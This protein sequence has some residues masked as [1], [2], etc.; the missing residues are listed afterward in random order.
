MPEQSNIIFHNEKQILESVARST[1][2]GFVAYNNEFQITYFS[3]KMEEV[4]GWSEKEMLGKDVRELYA[5]KTAVETPKI[6]EV[7][8]QIVI[9]FTKLG[10]QLSL[11]TKIT[12][13]SN[14]ENELE[15]FLVFFVIEDYKKNLDQAQSE[16]ISTVS[17]ELRTPITSIK[18]FAS[19]L[20]GQSDK[21]DEEKRRKYTKIIKDQAERL[22]RLVE[23]LLAVSRMENKKI[24]LTV[25]PVRIEPILETIIEV[26]KSKHSKSRHK[27]ELSCDSN[28]PAVWVDSD[29]LEQIL[30]NLIDNAIKYSPE[31]D[32]VEIVVRTTVK[33]GEEMV[34]VNITDYGIGI[35]KED[36]R[37]IFTKFSRLDSPL[38]R[39]TEGTG[40]GLYI[41]FSL[42]KLLHG[43]LNARSEA[44]K[45]TFS[46]Y[47]P[48]K[49]HSGGEVW[50][51]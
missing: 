26:V 1:E 32:K 25:H 17:H 51:D 5:I 24:E 33:D 47:L 11:E 22:S 43:D 6:D 29:R 16:F 37:K 27:M 14:D 30:T 34:R 42:A 40:L 20:L 46:L 13:I 23:D 4:T 45:T 39:V 38:T 28:L 18:G 12:P 50:W 10:K 2:N 31:A 3:K 36:L 41:S 19:T 8:S 49:E 48:T 35:K 15:G 7:E 21:I 9:L 44:S